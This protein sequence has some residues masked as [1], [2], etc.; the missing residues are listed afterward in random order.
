MGW[1]KT[2]N[3]V[4]IGLHSCDE[5]LHRISQK[6]GEFL[7]N[8]WHQGLSKHRTN[9]FKRWNRGLNKSKIFFIISVANGEKTKH[10]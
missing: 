7:L 9:S 10:K 6:V 2:E 3:D 8:S 1:W 5:K 4:K